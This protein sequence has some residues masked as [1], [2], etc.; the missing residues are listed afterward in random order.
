MKTDNR[1]ATGACVGP[2]KGCVNKACNRAAQHGPTEAQ[3]V[4]TV[5]EIRFA[6]R[7]G[8]IVE[9]AAKGA[10]CRRPQYRVSPRVPILTVACSIAARQALL[11][12]L[13]VRVL[14]GVA[15]SPSSTV[16]SPALPTSIVP[17]AAAVLNFAA[18]AVVSMRKMSRPDKPQSANASN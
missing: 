9:Q 4:V 6:H 7:G 3:R 11:R 14:K 12:L 2:R 17:V 8:M 18:G 10:Q 16:R 15:R 13:G 5:L 1:L